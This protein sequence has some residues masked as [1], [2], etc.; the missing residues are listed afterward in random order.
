MLLFYACEYKNKI[1]YENRRLITYFKDNL[2]ILSWYF[3][4]STLKVLNLH[5]LHCPDISNLTHRKGI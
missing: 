1:Y 2:L 5:T 4:E 3:F